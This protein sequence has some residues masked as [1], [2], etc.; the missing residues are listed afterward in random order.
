MSS[1]RPG[2][3]RSSRATR[4]RCTASGCAEPRAERLLAADPEAF[5]FGS[6]RSLFAPEALAEYERCL[7]DPRV[8]HAICEDY[9]AGATIDFALDEADRGMRS[10]GC[11]VLVLWGDTGPLGGQDVVATWAAWATDVRG[12]ALPCGHH[13]PEEAPAETAAALRAL[14]A[15]G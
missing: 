14:L 1:T 15:P 3:A 13:L 10:I 8:I 2:G 7:R 11:P 4:T 12:A 5:Y 6:R 9:R